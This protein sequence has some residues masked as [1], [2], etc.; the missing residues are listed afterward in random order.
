MDNVRLSGRY[1]ENPERIDE[2]GPNNFCTNMK[3]C[4]ISNT[5]NIIGKK[6][7]IL[8]LRNMMILNQTRFHQF[9][10]SIDDI[11]PKTLSIRLREMEKD[12]LIERTV[13]HEVPVRIEY[14]LTEKAMALTPVLEQ[15]ALFSM[16]YC[17]KDVFRGQPPKDVEK[18]Y[19][20]IR[21]KFHS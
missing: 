12:R 9:M 15:M 5:L 6:F 4:P 16:K 18:I 7:T 2:R 19:S 8:I 20:D 1:Q 14:T 21:S 17:S 13:Y 3:I 10:D 11:N